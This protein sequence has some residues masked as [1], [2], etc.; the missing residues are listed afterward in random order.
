LLP[1]AR[2]KQSRVH[3]VRIWIDIDGVA[4]VRG[5]NL[6]AA[7]RWLDRDFDFDFDTDC[8]GLALPLP[9][10]FALLR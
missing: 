10:S 6:G 9:C 1:G 3:E 7:I 4:S 8:E 5:W 2:V